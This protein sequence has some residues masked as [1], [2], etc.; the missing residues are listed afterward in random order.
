MCILGGSRWFIKPSRRETWIEF[1]AAAFG[2][3]LAAANVWGVTQQDLSLS[4][5]L[6]F[7]HMVN[8]KVEP[9]LW[10]SR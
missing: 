5:F 9:V 8:K 10:C 2:P 4:V 7:K 3:T 1:Y 6:Q